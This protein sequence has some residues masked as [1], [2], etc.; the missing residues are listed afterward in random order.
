[1]TTTAAP[2]PEITRALRMTDYLRRSPA[3]VGGPSFHKE[4]QHF[5]VY[6]DD[7]ELLVNVNL[8]DAPTVGAGP[9]PSTSTRTAEVLR[10]IVMVRAPDWQGRVDTFAFSDFQVRDGGHHLQFPGGDVH[11]RD[12][13][14]HVRFTTGDGHIQ[15]ALEFV[16]LTRPAVANNQSLSAGRTLRWLFVPS[17]LCR[18][19]L[20]V[21]STT[22]QFHDARAYH[23][24][25]WGFFQWG[26]DF[27]WEWGSALP[28]RPD[29]PWSVVFMRM[30]NRDRT[31][32]R[33]QGVY[34]WRDDRPWRIFRDAELRI[35]TAFDEVPPNDLSLPPMMALLC[36]PGPM[37]VPSRLEIIARGEG[38]TLR[39]LFR[40]THLARVIVPSEVNTWSTTTLNEVSGTLAA[41]GRVRGQSV[42][43]EGAGVF[44]FVRN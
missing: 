19:Q 37:D 39:L 32:T 2:S 33:C 34:L 12:G 8:L 3:R 6:G 20:R 36:P 27:S 31:T 26:D 30:G 38:D 29:L 16:P 21:G 35:T 1:M 25:N 40:P 17:L 22:H 14:Y 42:S 28:T 24:H 43:F 10:L 18:G 9:G 23:D 4:W 44:E 15:A 11:F 13:R 5:I 41:S 7:V